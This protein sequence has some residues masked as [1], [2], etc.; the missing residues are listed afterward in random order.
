MNALKH[1]ELLRNIIH[2]ASTQRQYLNNSITDFTRNRKLSLETMLNLIIAMQG[3]SLNREF[4]D[5]DTKLDITTSAFIQQRDKIKPELF[6]YIFH[7]YNEACSDKNRYKGYK[8]LA[9]DGT[10]V[11]IAY[12]PNSETYISNENKNNKGFNQFH[13][14]T[15]YDVLNKVYIDCIIQPKSKCNE[16]SACTNMVKAN[17]FDKSILIADRGYGSLNLV[18]TINRTNNLEYL[19]RVKNDWL[20]EIKSLPMKEFDT[21]IT[22]EL[23]TTATKADKKLYAEGKAKWIS[24]KSK[25]G[26]YK[27]STTW[28][29]ESPYKM[30]LRVVRFEISENTYETIV[31]SLNKKDFPLK[32]IKHLYHLRWNIETSFRELKYAVGLVNFHAKKESSIIQEIY[33]RLIMYNFCERITIEIV[34]K[35]DKNRKWTYQINYTMAI[36][37]CRDFY[38]YHNN[39]P[40]PNVELLI[41]KYILPVRPNRK[42]NRKMKPKSVVYF[43]YRVA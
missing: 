43:L 42:D 40:P 14:N 32:E 24:G 28:E 25:F 41:E 19:F 23:R 27:K 16:M 1:K 36:H 15:I 5:Y 26:K 4:Y 8:L 29:Y 12:N 39:E 6:Q 38:R 20:T 2:I 9:V 13:I 11:N 33:A 3:G 37:I 30:T 34:I 7:K 31:T 22:F 35:Q 17:F 21:E 10:D 18:E